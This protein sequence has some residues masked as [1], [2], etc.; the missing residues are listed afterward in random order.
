M[1]QGL[2]EKVTP[3]NLS[4][5]VKGYCLD[6]FTHQRRNSGKEVPDIESEWAEER[7]D[8]W[9]GQTE[10][11]FLWKLRGTL[12]WLDSTSGSV[13]L[14]HCAL[15]RAGS[16]SVLEKWQPLASIRLWV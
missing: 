14:G 16:L 2:G 6:G 7:V 4:D 9:S 11:L 5:P 3:A 12:T 10:G 15:S 13:S 8:G 1:L